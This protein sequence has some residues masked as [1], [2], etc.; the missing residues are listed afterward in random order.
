MSARVVVFGVDGLTFRV[1]H[2][3]MERGALPNFRRL[4]EKGCE[5]VLESK[6]PPIT[7]PAW[8]SLS[9]GLK[10]ARHGV[11][12]FWDFEQQQGLASPRV[13]RLLTHRKGGKAIWNILSEYGKKVL[14]INV[15]M[16][17]PPETVNGIIISGY[18]TPGPKTNFTYPASFKEELFRIVPDYEIDLPA[19]D[20]TVGVGARKWRVLDATLRMTKR[21]FKLME[22]LLKE[23]EWDFSFLGFVGAD[24][25][26][27]RLWDE[28]LSLD[29]HATE[30]YHQ[31][32]DGLGRIL[33]LLG[34]DDSLYV[35]SDHGFQGVS[36]SFEINEYLYSRGLVTL[37][38]H[39]Q[40][41]RERA[42]RKH[43]LSYTLKRMGLFELAKK[44]KR[45]VQKMDVSQH[46]DPHAHDPHKLK[47][48]DID[49]Q[50]T[51]AYV[52]SS[53]GFGSGYADIYLSQ[54]MHEEQIA[55]LCADLLSMV[56]PKTGKPLLEAI[57]TTE[58]FGRGPYAPAE[59]HLLL[60]P[61]DGMTFRRGLGNVRFWDDAMMANDPSKRSG[62][63]QKDGVL[64]VY[65]K[66]FKQ[67]FQAPN[68]EIYDLVP[69][70][71]QTMGLLFSNA[72]DGRVLEELFVE[73]LQPQ[74]TT[75]IVSN[76][77]EGSSA[78]HKLKKLL[79]G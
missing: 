34:P 22:H 24:R 70:V 58:A 61:N 54:T 13:P 74:R 48:A 78:H 76:S 62:V 47:A 3:L 32:D 57:Y 55:E 26:Q 66:Q 5:A 49:W 43:A 39:S 52:P 42:S 18:M 64:Y 25:I 73:R 63:H 8:I 7:P 17:Y 2:P 14:V 35:V 30:Y 68:A 45:I 36:R 53:S 79:E 77:M 33:D 37:S 67:G 4:K 50:H 72:F 15:P 27:H 28:I 11:Y 21:R 51:Q 20:K 12:D 10:P 65:G 75:T 1:L 6:Y 38:R 71:L 69:T 59:P 19:E 60:L 44:T 23:K 56:D 9:T 16:T 31:L 29:A 41:V 46:L 40:Q